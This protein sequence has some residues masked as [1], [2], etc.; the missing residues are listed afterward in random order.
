MTALLLGI[1]I[2][3]IGL[4]AARFWGTFCGRNRI[5]IE[6]AVAGGMLFGGVSFAIGV[7]ILMNH[8]WK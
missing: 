5:P 1:G 2:P 8:F 4:L 6:F 3:V 7:M